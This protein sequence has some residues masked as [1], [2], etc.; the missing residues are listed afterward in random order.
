MNLLQEIRRRMPP[1]REARYRLRFG[2]ALGSMIVSL[3]AVAVLSAPC[4][5]ESMPS[6]EYQLKASYIYH[7]T[8]FIKWPAG[9]LQG[10]NA[11]LSICLVGKDPFGKAL[12]V[13]EGK[14][15]HGARI[16]VHRINNPMDRDC[17]IVYINVAGTVAEKK[18][19]EASRREGVLMLGE[20]E[21]F[22]RNGGTMRFLTKDDRVRFQIDK[23][24]AEKA[25]LSI[26]KK[27]MSVA[28][29]LD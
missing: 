29:P 25:G 26:P 16:K 22:I 11:T 3:V 20:S 12:D 2:R 7:F 1:S 14:M 24:S 19:I 23:E 6:P 21:D 27:L 8:K 18:L 28:V 17:Q 10:S 13:I 15:S 4:R 9:T 5:A